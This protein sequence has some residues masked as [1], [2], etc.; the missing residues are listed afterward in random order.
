MLTPHPTLLIGPADWEPAHMP[1]QEF[2]RRID[3][4]WGLDPHAERIRAWVQDERLQLTRVQELLAGA[5]RRHR[6]QDRLRRRE[7]D[8]RVGRGGLLEGISRSW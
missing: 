1:R 2:E 5:R 4:L 6:E 3:A 7:E 8:G